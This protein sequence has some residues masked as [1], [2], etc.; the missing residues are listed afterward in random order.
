M[1]VFV[2]KMCFW[3]SFTKR[4]KRK[5]ES[6]ENVLLMLQA[7]LA[8]VDMQ[9]RGA[10]ASGLGSYPAALLRCLITWRVKQ[11]ES[12]WKI[13]I[14]CSLPA[15]WHPAK[16]ALSARQHQAGSC[17]GFLSFWTHCVEE[18][19]VRNLRFLPVLCPCCLLDSTDRYSCFFFFL[20]DL[21]FWLFHLHSGLA[22]KQ[23]LYQQQQTLTS[24]GLALMNGFLFS[25]FLPD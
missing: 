14:S 11:P 24:E 5:W 3:V 23:Y 12:V 13:S 21:K 20:M 4:W 1:D 19:L 16:P 6:E 18:G 17:P 22:M 9:N 25:W 7:V 15:L 10:S 2:G 8:E